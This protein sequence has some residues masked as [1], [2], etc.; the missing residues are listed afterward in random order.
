MDPGVPNQGVPIWIIGASILD[1]QGSYLAKENPI[2]EGSNLGRGVPLW[3]LKAPT[4]ER[5]NG[6]PL[7]TLGNSF[8][9]LGEPNLGVPFWIL[10]GFMLDHE[11]SNLKK[12]GH[13]LNLEVF[14]LERGEGSPLQSK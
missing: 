13:T 8:W 6:V 14:N 3:T 5:K 4:W 9:T 11:G 7:W 1:L 10:G 12:E 2:P